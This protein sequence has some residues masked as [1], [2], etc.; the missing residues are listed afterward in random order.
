MA[1]KKT[2]PGSAEETDQQYPLTVR[3]DDQ[4][5]SYVLPSRD[6]GE[7]HDLI[8]LREYWYV[9]LKRR[10]A[11]IIFF[12]I[13]FVSVLIGTFLQTPLYRGTSLVQIETESNRVM[14]FK[15]A[16]PEEKIGGKDFYVTQYE[17]LKSNTLA[18]RVIDQL[19]LGARDVGSHEGYLSWLGS[20]FQ[21]SESDLEKEKRIQAKE[22]NLRNQKLKAFLSSLS[23]EPV[24]NSRLVKIHFNSPDPN[25]SAR[26]ANLVAENFITVNLE[27]KYQANAYAKTFLEERIAQVKTKLEEAER[28]QVEYAK[29]EKIFNFDK[30]AESTNSQSLQDF[31]QA[32]GRAQQERIKAESVYR[33]LSNVKEGELPQQLE[34]A[35]IQQLKASKAKLESDYQE[36][37][38]TFKP[39]YP[40]MA[41]LKAQ[42]DGLG[43]QIE[44]ESVN[45]RKSI[46]IAYETAKSNET[47]LNSKLD[48]Q[49]DA[50][51]DLQGRSIQFNIL[52]R[53]SDTNRQLYDG[54]LQRLK[55]VSVTGD[56]NAN[57]ILIIDRSQ[58]P[59]QQFSPN[60]TLNLTI[61][62]LLGVFGGFGLALLFEY[63]DN[64]FKNV[65]DIEKFLGMPVLGLIPDSPEELTSPSAIIHETM[66]NTK[67]KIVEAFRSTRTA[68]QFSTSTGTPKV[69]GLTSCF[70]SE[71]KS[72][73]SLSLAIHFAQCGSSVLL[74]D[75]DL[76]R[77]ALHK[78]FEIE[79]E[80]GLSN[81]LAGLSAAGDAIHTTPIK[82]LYFLSAGTLPPNPAELMLNGRFEEFIEKAK[83]KFDLILIDGP[84]I[85]G[86]AD[87]VI[88]ANL[89]EKLLIVVEAGKTP[90]N[91]A[92]A[93]MKRL[94]S[95]GIKPLGV[96][97]NKMKNDPLGYGYDYYYYYAHGYYGE[98][99]PENK[100]TSP[101]SNF[102]KQIK[103]R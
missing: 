50:L 82:N 1:K 51:L 53:E 57:N 94:R 71:G 13:V 28:A 72:T 97:F 3:P 83:E 101:F 54:L 88:I 87:A 24:R 17:L 64:T 98:E 80:V 59:Q 16:S 93:A 70:A 35:L 99:K 74:V 92:S 96:I 15:D 103:R 2:I 66:N 49:K 18:Q 33:E 10:W 61:A 77:A 69:L 19:N 43:V 20:F 26:V 5:G 41:Q 102:M 85:L 40:A 56:V 32:L 39:A 36:K 67:S 55:E 23:I 38:K 37:L 34:S 30:G 79:N 4:V 22:E 21:G 12:I 60:I 48:T 46:R 68:L 62:I 90:R 29:K 78:A 65:S 58:V 86:L 63:L 47:M 75:A 8:D 44:K 81:I 6:E 7:D 89:V 11:I 45:V 9:I 84:P 76:R 73:T 100:K 14:D 52:K 27:K 42:I 31:N 91:M 25:L 95:S